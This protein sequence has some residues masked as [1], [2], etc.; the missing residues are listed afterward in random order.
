MEMNANPVVNETSSYL[1][2]SL[3]CLK[4]RDQFSELQ[5][6]L[7]F[8]TVHTSEGQYLFYRLLWNIAPKFKYSCWFGIYYKKMIWNI[9]VLYA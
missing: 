6:L 1:F 7:A 9:A 2:K 3:A 8:Q 4:A 5:K